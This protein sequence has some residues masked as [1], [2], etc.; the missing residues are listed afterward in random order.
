VVFLLLP[1]TGNS[2]NVDTIESDRYIVEI[3][4]SS[5]HF[6]VNEDGDYLRL[7]QREIC[8]YE[9]FSFVGQK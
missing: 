5:P 2:S 4:F 7:Y 6:E 9:Q 1:L 3:F 8:E